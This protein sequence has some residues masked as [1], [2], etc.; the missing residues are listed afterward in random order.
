MFTTCNINNLHHQVQLK[1]SL[2]GYRLLT[3]ETVCTQNNTSSLILNRLESHQVFISRVILQQTKCH[4]RPINRLLRDNN[5]KINEDR[6]VRLSVSNVFKTFREV[7]KNTKSEAICLFYLGTFQEW[8]LKKGRTDAWRREN[9]E[10]LRSHL[11][12]Q[13]LLKRVD[14]HTAH[15]LDWTSPAINRCSFYSPLPSP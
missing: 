6:A 2:T 8:K 10:S 4:S 9:G 3:D 1:K 7:R 14:A 15:K 12:K 13:A 11:H 5:E